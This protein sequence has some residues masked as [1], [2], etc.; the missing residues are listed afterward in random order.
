MINSPLCYYCHVFCWH[1]SWDFRY[2]T[3]KGVTSTGWVGWTS[4]VCPVVLRNWC[5]FVAPCSIKG[6][7]ILVYS[8]VSSDRDILCRHGGWDIRCPTSESVTGTGWVGWCSYIGAII[9]RDWCDLI[10]TCS[11]K[12]DGVLINN[13]PRDNG[14]IF[15]YWFVWINRIS[16][17][18][19]PAHKFVTRFFR[20]CYFFNII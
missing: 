5:D 18:I 6:D 9:L 20:V 10:A 3:S 16:I 8:P 12:G 1:N 4:Y 14:G 19:F 7:S 15:F 11:V 13:V 17:F 2:P